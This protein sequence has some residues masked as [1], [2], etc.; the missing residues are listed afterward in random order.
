MFE[1]DQGAAVSELHNP[2]HLLH[3]R[4]YLHQQ[5]GR[6]SAELCAAQKAYNQCIQEIIA[7]NDALRV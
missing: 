2:E 4:L 6:I 7:T 1:Q 3:R 5:L